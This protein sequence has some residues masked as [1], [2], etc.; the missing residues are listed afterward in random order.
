[1]KTGTK[2]I[3]L[4]GSTFPDRTME[5]ER[6]FCSVCTV[7][8]KYSLTLYLPNVFFQSLSH[9][10]QQILRPICELFDVVPPIDMAFSIG[11]DGTF[12][13]TAAAIGR[14]G[15]PIF[16]INTGR[17]GFLADVGYDNLES[18][19]GE[20]AEGKFRI[21]SRTLLEIVTDDDT[22]MPFGTDLKALNEV[23]IMKQE[24]ASMLTI[25][26]HINGEYLT[27]YQADGLIVSTPTGSTAYSLSIGGPI[28][29]P[30]S[31]S[32]ILAAIAPHSLTSRPLVVDN[33][34]CISLKVESRSKNFL[35]S[36]D[37]ESQIFSDS[38]A[39]KIRKADY[40]LRVMKRLEHTFFD[41]LREKLMWGADIR[42]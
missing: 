26:A 12:L 29:M 37:G 27:T 42:L 35:V 16:G 10:S 14:S 22:F 7:L 20:I 8:T 19:I 4:F 11:G 34:S 32:L 2:K 1:M 18:A 5:A 30:T 13:R 15:I 38:M 39:I 31:S 3:A 6:R 25:H 28:L 17:L 24:T 23:A 36:M 33:D 9:E 21:E 40:K 41:T